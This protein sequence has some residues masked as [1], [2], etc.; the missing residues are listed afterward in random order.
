VPL[1]RKRWFAPWA[2]RCKPLGRNPPQPAII[3][4]LHVLQGY[5]L[6]RAVASR[7]KVDIDAKGPS[8]PHIARQYAV[9]QDVPALGAERLAP[10]AGCSKGGS[11]SAASKEITLANTA[12]IKTWGAG[13]SYGQNNNSLFWCSD[14]ILVE[15]WSQAGRD[16]PRSKM[17][18]SVF[19]FSD[20]FSSSA[21]SESMGISTPT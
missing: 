21:S 4:D 8:P 11:V 18:R 15:S 19:G 16:Y 3:S 10:A 2:A 14:R 5:E 7:H 6:D 9:P 20:W 1:R 13:E 12:H 17:W